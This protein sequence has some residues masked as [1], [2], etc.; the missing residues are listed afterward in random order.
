MPLIAPFHALCPPP[1]RAVDV[2]A[3]PYDV[4]DTAEARALAVG[5]PWSFLHLS[6]PEIDLEPPPDP[7]APLDYRPA[8]ALLARMQAE[9]VL[10]RDPRP[11]CWVYRLS[12]AGRDQTG[13]AAAFSIA[14]YRVGRIRRHEL[15][16]AEK[17]NDRVR[18]IAALGAQTG[19]AFLIHRRDPTID[20]PLAQRAMSDPDLDCSARDGVRHRL[21][22]LE[23]PE[24]VAR[25]AA[26][27][28]AQPRLYIADGHHR[29]A[30][31]AR[32]DAAQA[33]GEH[34]GLAA[35]R[36]LAVSFPA[37]A[38]RIL[39]V[40]RLVRD[41]NGLAA[42]TFL[43]RVRERCALEASPSPV[44]PGRRGEAGLYLD[45]SWYRLSLDS[46][47]G[48]PAAPGSQGL[49]ACK[50]GTPGPAVGE[51]P[52]RD[53]AA[54]L[55]ARRLQD[56]LLAPVLG[57]RDP[58]R[59][60]RLDFVGGIRGLQGL[61]APVDSGAMRAAFALYPTAMDDLL[62]IADAGATMP[63]KCTWFEPKLADGLLS[64][65]LD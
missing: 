15:T 61:T 22:R 56:R 28:E 53:P 39:P 13:L 45:R 2:L 41:L 35:G 26:A 54:H 58:R 17:E 64:L 52:G 38:L 36:L 12:R 14:A 40:H 8:A 20:D 11:C 31:A 9:G 24:D 48:P 25:I 33:A 3:P 30:A 65:P 34:R 5:R 60:P 62:A 18:Q 6:R 21:W 43:A 47:A 1:K 32:V 27:F 4:I 7:A 49:A 16:L 44:L 63:P 46:A 10:V 19:P 51:A 55:D 59:D 29:S 37:D 50:E 42:E 57:I 23:A